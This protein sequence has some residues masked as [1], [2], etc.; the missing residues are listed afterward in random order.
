MILISI[1]FLFIGICF[2]Q[3]TVNESG[4]ILLG[5]S[6][7]TGDI[8]EKCFTPLKEIYSYNDVKLN[9]VESNSHSFKYVLKEFPSSEKELFDLEV[10]GYCQLPQ[11]SYFPK[12]YGSF[13]RA[14]TGTGVIV[15]EFI[16]GKNLKEIIEDVYCDQQFKHQKSNL[17]KSF[18]FYCSRISQCNPNS[19]R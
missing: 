13:R 16:D 8:I 15:M 17:T 5:N 1:S 6:G 10:K 11:S 3:L 4:E 12:Y 14:D 18:K 2:G 7:I 9:L 19:A